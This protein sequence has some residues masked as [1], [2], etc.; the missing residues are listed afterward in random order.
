HIPSSSKFFAIFA[1]DKL[2]MRMT[3]YVKKVIS[4]Y[5]N[6]TFEGNPAELLEPRFQ[7]LTSHPQAY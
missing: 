1:T 5:A 2:A 7:S 4:A 3:T 6:R